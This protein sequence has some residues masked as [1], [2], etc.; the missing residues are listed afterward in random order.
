MIGDIAS[1]DIFVSKEEQKQA[2]LAKLP[3]ILCVEMEGAAVAQVCYEHQIPFTVIRTV[4]D[5]ADHKSIIDFD[6]FVTNIVG[7]YSA[8]IIKNLFDIYAA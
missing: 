5:A 4:S 1:G 7:V 2:L 8:Q 3:T 6:S